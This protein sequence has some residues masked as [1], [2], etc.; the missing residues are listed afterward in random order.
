MRDALKLYHMDHAYYPTSTASGNWCS[1]EIAPGNPKACEE[2][3]DTS[4]EFVLE[5]YLGKKPEDVLFGQGYSYH[6]VSDTSGRGYMIH[7]NLE[8]RKV[9]GENFYQIKVGIMGPI[10]LSIPP[11]P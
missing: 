11:H 8:K 9:E 1:L 2:L 7:A 10:S 4:G 5:P 6:Y 3:Y